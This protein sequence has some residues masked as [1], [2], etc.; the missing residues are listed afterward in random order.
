VLSMWSTSVRLMTTLHL[1][2]NSFSNFLAECSG[3]LLSY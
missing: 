1:S 2:D 3:F